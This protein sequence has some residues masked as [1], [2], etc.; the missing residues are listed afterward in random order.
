MDIIV[1]LLIG[2][3]ML[4]G[5]AI[6]WVIYIEAPKRQSERYINE[7]QAEAEL[8]SR[9]KFTVH[10]NVIAWP[11]V[12]D[13]NVHVEYKPIEAASV[14]AQAV[15]E[16]ATVHDDAVALID[17]TMRMPSA[18]R[19]D[20]QLMTADE[21]QSAG[22]MDRDRR[23][24]AVGYLCRLYDVQAVNNAG[25]TGNGV[26]YRGNNGDLSRL[27]LD[28]A[29]TKVPYPNQKPPYSNQRQSTAA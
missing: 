28:L 7:L 24:A 16:S 25:P 27:M 13:G 17:A 4:I 10:G 14:Q 3:I 26:F 18:S 9:V 1:L 6:A 2:A 21:C 8:L 19:K 5:L 23:Q 12:R 20:N 15:A 11:V 29:V 22:V